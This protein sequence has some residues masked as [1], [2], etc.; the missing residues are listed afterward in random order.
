MKHPMTIIAVDN[1]D[2]TKS[3]YTT[4]V[5]CCEIRSNFSYSY[6]KDVE[7]PILYKGIYY[8]E[9]IKLNERD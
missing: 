5:K 1:E 6:L 9:R 3:T 8:I 7:L 2:G 4:L